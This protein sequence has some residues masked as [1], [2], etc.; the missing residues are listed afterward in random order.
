M[1][2]LFGF[3]KISISFLKLIPDLSTIN[4]NATP[5]TARAAQLTTSFSGKKSGHTL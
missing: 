1:F 5:Y 4:H 3:T 2:T